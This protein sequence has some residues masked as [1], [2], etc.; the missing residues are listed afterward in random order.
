M[1]ATTAVD[2]TVAVVAANPRSNKVCACDSNNIDASFPMRDKLV[3]IR[4]RPFENVMNNLLLLFRC[5]NQI[6]FWHL[7]SIV[8]VSLHLCGFIYHW[9]LVCVITCKNMHHYSFHFVFILCRTNKQK[10]T[11]THTRIQTHYQFAKFTFKVAVIG[12]CTYLF[13]FKSFVSMS[14]IT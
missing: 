10:N 5:L 3:F 9:N 4:G 2:F 6:E 11:H 1:I 7:I 12:F 13:L 14:N 8:C